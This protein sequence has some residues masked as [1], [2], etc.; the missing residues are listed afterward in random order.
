MET[1]CEKTQTRVGHRQ[2]VRLRDLTYRDLAADRPTVAILPWAATEAHNQHLPHGTDLIEAEEF[3]CRSAQSARDRGA[4][5]VVLPSIPFGNNAQQQDQIATVHFSTATASA[6]LHDVVSSLKRQG[7]TRLL[8]LNGH[9]GNDFKPLVRDMILE[10]GVFL[11]VVNFWEMCPELLHDLFTDP[12]DHAGALETSLLLYLCPQHVRLE[13][14]GSGQR[15]PFCATAL[16]QAGVWTPRPWSRI[17]PDLG[18]G[19]PLGASAEKGERV[20]AAI[21]AA[22][23][24][25]LVQLSAAE[26][27]P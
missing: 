17:H 7:I 5:V 21:S 23:A 15:R 22:I 6:I 27:L 10:T 12:G 1:S 8:I 3:A 18:S 2:S 4:K 13:A 9:G 11:A 24:E 26:Q 19:N 16:Q 14:A 25:L 20:F